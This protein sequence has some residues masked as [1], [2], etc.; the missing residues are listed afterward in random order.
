ML[1]D[2]YDDDGYDYDDQDS[3]KLLL[4]LFLLCCNNNET[5]MK[6]IPRFLRQKSPLLVSYSWRHVML[7]LR[8]CICRLPLSLVSTIPHICAALPSTGST[9]SRDCVM[10]TITLP[11]SS[12]EM[13]AHPSV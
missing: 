10:K 1:N 9:Q 12:R 2:D 6:E 4:F 8:F 13:H 7:Q 3:L 5:V 11:S